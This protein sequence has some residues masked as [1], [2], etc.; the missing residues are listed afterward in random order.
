M[1]RQNDRRFYCYLILG[2][3]IPVVWLAL[4]IAPAMGKGLLG[5]V[6]Q[7][8]KSMNDP[9]MI[10]WCKDSLKTVLIFLAAYGIGI[11]IYWSTRKNY[12]RLEEHGSAKWGNIHKINKRY[13]ERN[14]FQNKL[15]TQ[16]ISI[17]FDGHWHKRNLHVIVVGGSGSGKT[18]TYCLPNL[19]QVN[20]S[21]VVLDP[22]GE[23]LRMTGYL[24]EK[25]GYVIKV[26]DLINLE[27][28]HCYNPFVYLKSDNDVQKLVTNI[29]KSTT[30][31]GT[32]SNDPF[33]DTSA[34]M[35]LMALIL[36]LVHE[37]PEDEQNFAMVME[38]IRAGAINEEDDMYLSPL[39]QLF[40]DLEAKEPS[41]IAVKYYKNYRSGAAKTLKS[42]QITLAARLEKFNLESVE[43]L[44]MTDELDFGSLGER[45][46]ALFAI[47]PDNDKSLNYLVSIMYTQLFQQLFY[48]ADY[49]Y[50]GEL[51]VHVHFLM[52]EFSNVTLPDEFENLLAVMR[53]RGISV[54][55]LLQNLT[56]LK[57]LF[58]K[59]WESIIGHC[60]ELLYLGGNEKSTHQYVS[61]SLGKETID[62]NTY[63]KSEGKSGSYSTN[64]QIAGRELLTPDEVRMLDNKYALL[65]IRGERPVIDLKYDTMHHPNIKFTSFG[66]G[67][68]YIHGKVSE[69]VGTIAFYHELEGKRI[70][71]D[72]SYAEKYELLSESELQMQLEEKEKGEKES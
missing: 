6:E 10:I 4:I 66:G 16:H 31:K 38:M 13:C 33:W 49:K 8:D 1:N 3:M 2:G 69:D 18:L 61:E 62:T 53:G 65:F 9:L 43:G 41:H 58:E 34:S 23:L 11:G 22:K 63:G 15:L 28:S 71:Y 55:I 47:L 5:I 21:F 46:T 44:T 57:V 40:Y 37:A 59:Q 19:C 12:R 48:I 54:S 27:K 20:T 50:R 67:K 26:L 70:A 64:Y 45:K 7:F 25:E 17:S 51:P 39:D 60:D 56:Q 68:T 35:L 24:L 14:S 29:F 30:P 36:Y 72:A 42:I 32:Q 52:D